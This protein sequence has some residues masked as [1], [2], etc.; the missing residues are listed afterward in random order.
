MIFAILKLRA[1]VARR[2]RVRISYLIVTP[3]STLSSRPVT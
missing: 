2:S 1:T 3:A